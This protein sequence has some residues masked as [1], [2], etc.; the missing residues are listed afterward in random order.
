MAR[1]DPLAPDP[2]LNH[3][4]F[5]HAPALWLALPLLAGCAL[6]L[7]GRPD[8]GAMLLAGAV[9]VALG[10]AFVGRAHLALTALAIGGILL[11]AVWHQVRTP[12]IGPVEL[13]RPFVELSILV[14]RA[15]ERKDGEG[16][17]GLGWVTDRDSRLFRRRLALS[18]Q[19]PTPGRRRRTEDHR[20]PRQPRGRPAR[21]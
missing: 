12:P 3:L 13:R 1:L 20:P 19:G 10:W 11:G 15:N 5:G 21:L 9:A 7:A 16:W 14:E 17:T 6:D 4:R 18:V 2:G 8:S